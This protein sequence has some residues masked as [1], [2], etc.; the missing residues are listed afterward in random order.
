MK[1]WVLLEI[2]FLPKGFERQIGTFVDH[3]NNYCYPESP[4]NLTPADVY[5]GR[6]AKILNIRV[7]IKKQTIRNRRFQNKAAATFT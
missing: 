3:N 1:N 7:E 5:H 4:A 6:D 2:Y